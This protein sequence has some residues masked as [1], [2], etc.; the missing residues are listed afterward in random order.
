M[1]RDR[2]FLNSL[3]KRASFA[4]ANSQN[5]TEEVSERRMLAKLMSSQPLHEAAKALSSSFSSRLLQPQCRA[6]RYQRSFIPA[7]VRLYN[8]HIG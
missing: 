2:T 7:A 3:V 4:L 6:E 1:E 5:S 8:I